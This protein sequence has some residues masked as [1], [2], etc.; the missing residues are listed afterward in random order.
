MSTKQTT[1]FETLKKQGYLFY[2]T[3]PNYKGS[4]FLSIINGK[5]YYDPEF[6]N[7]IEMTEEQVKEILDI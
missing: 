1:L 4:G 3:H 7:R 6:S 2:I 5:F